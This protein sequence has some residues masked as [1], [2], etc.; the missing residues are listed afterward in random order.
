MSK[1]TL[2]NLIRID[3]YVLEFFKESEKLNAEFLINEI[4]LET[5]K[6]IF[7]SST[8]DDE[9]L[10]LDYELIMPYDIDESQAEMINQNLKRS[11][12]FDFEKFIYN[13]QRYGVYK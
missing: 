13:F 1:Y 3:T 4:P 6:T 9:G 8:L 10:H 12:K 11:I 5:L 2:E 7:K